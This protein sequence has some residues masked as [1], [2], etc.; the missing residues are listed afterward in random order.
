MLFNSLQFIYFLPIVIIGY[1]LLPHKFR[2]ILLLLASY[3][4]Y[5]CW[6]ADYIIL[7]VVST[8]ID[9]FAARRMGQ[10]TERKR[11]K[12]YLI[13]S[14]FTNLGLLGTF[15]YFN[16]FTENI[17]Q[18][19]EYFNVASQIPALNL[20]LPVGISFYTFQT[21]SYSI[22]V[23]YGKIK[24]ETHL[25]HFALYV[26][27]FPQLV[28]GPIE[29]FDRLSPQLK[30]KH[31][32][33]YE[34]LANGLRLILYGLFI[35][36]VIAD[37]LSV[38]V[39]QIYKAPE[40]FSS[41]GLLTGVSLYSFQIY[42]DFYGYST[43]AIGS[44]LI[45]GIRIMDNF[46]TP[47]LARSVSEFWE[48]WHISL[49]TWFRSYLYFPLGGN[50]VKKYR[51]MINIFIVFAVSGLWH[52]ANWTFIIWGAMWGILYLVENQLNKLFKFQK[53]AKEWSL[54]HF[55]M[56]TKIFVISTVAWI[57]F[58]S[59]SFSE[60]M[61]ILKNIVT[62]TNVEK[63]LNVEPRILLL[64]GLFIFSDIFLFNNRFDKWSAKQN[65]VL[66]WVIY[67]FLLFSIIVFSG[68]EDFPFIYFQF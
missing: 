42:S 48:R 1:F 41:W 7:I 12:K 44:A 23:Y 38:Y 67:A 49:S 37:N 11:R 59:Q 47:Y 5:M 17:N 21:L 26:S 10:H 53:I 52:G 14:L 9:F 68:V 24:P 54:R 63:Q 27:F 56:A 16:F 35:K 51:W 8:L 31:N 19:F 66:R 2:W 43:I 30:A 64:L 4:F 58:R 25:G 32:F 46:K 33:S 29:R 57:F 45:M 34:N 55:I 40:A 39:D 28:A 62:N 6:R 65:V 60:A 22:D 18:L 13:L 15:K 36:M 50:R 20:L 61:T 3:Y